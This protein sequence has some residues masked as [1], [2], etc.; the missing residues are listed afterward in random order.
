MDRMSSVD[1]APRQ[2][3]YLGL[4]GLVLGLGFGALVL[5][6]VA[7]PPRLPQELPGWDAVTFTLQGSYLPLGA[8]AYVLTTAAWAVWL[9]IV[10]SLALR[11]VVL[12]TEAMTGGA[13]WVAGLRSVSDRVT[14][15]IV[16]RLVDGALVAIVVVNLVG[17]STPSAA[18]AVL[19]SAA[20][21]SVVA[22]Q[23]GAPPRQAFDQSQPDREQRVVEYTVQAGDTLWGIAERF[24]GTGHEYPR[25]VA[26][27][28]GRQMPDGRRFT[29]AGVIYPGWV[30]LVH[31]TSQGTEDAGGQAYY[32]VEER[33][34]LRGIAARVLDDES[35]WS[36]IFELNRGT[37]R[38]VDGRVLEDPGLIWPGLRLRLPSSVP[39]GDADEPTP[40]A[41]APSQEDEPVSPPDSPIVEAQPTVI[42]A[43]PEGEVVVDEPS[44]ALTPTAL[45]EPE[46]APSTGAVSP[47]VYGAAGLVTIAVTGGAM[48]LARRRVRRSLD[49]LPVRAVSEVGSPP[50]GDFA[51]AEFGRVLAHRL[52]GDE[53][54]P[55]VLVAEQVLRFLGEHGM[56]EASVVMA[57]Q[58]RNATTL[59]L[60]VGLLDQTCLLDL[61]SEFGARL[62]G[63][64]QA[65]ITPDHD[66]AM[67]LSGLKLAGVITPSSYRLAAPPRLLPVGVIPKGQTLY[68]NWRE[69]GHILVAGL[70]GGGTGVVLTS[71]ISALA[72]RCR[73]EE[74][75]LWTV[76]DRRLLPAQLL[77]LPHQCGA[78]VD[79]ADK[80]GVSQV[81]QQVRT[82]LIRRMRE[83]EREDG[84]RPGFRPE[85]PEIVLAIGELGNLEDD[86]TTLELIGVHGAAHGVRLLAATTGPAELTVELL[87]HFQT[88]LVLQTLD[89]EES[90]R[91]LGRPDAAD[92]GTGDLLLR[93]D[94]R[95]LV[96]ARGFRVSSDR[97]DELVR[98]MRE[99]YGCRTPAVV[100]TAATPDRAEGGAHPGAG[101]EDVPHA[102]ER[103][104]TEDRA[105]LPTEPAPEAVVKSSVHEQP[106]RTDEPATP[107]EDASE[108]DT[109]P[110]DL[111]SA[112]DVAVDEDRSNGHRD[113]PAPD[114]ISP[115]DDVGLR[116]A[117]TTEE[118]DESSNGHGGDTVHGNT[119]VVVARGLAAKEEIAPEAGTLVQVRCFGEFLV[120][121]G[122]REITPS[123]E[124]GAS[125]KAWEVLAFLAAQ[126]DG[127]VSREKLLAAVWPDVD[128]E[129]AGNRMRVAMVRLR[130][131]LARQ[132]PC[133][134]SEAVR[135]DRD[136]TC[137]LDTKMISSD[138]HQFVALCRTTPKLPPERA[139]AVLQQA[140]ALYGGELLPGR[141]TRLYEWVDERDESGVSLREAYREE[142]YRATQRLARLFFQEGR[143]ELAVPLYRG[144]LKAE[145]TLE[146]IVRELYRCYQ[147]IGDLSSLIREDRHLRQALR[148]AYH[149][150]DDPE[151]NP[152]DYQPEP[153]TIELFSKIRRELE[154]KVAARGDGHRTGGQ[155]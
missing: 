9:W 69:L 130:A 10:A 103:A 63:T 89:D 98:L 18:A 114:H 20:T 129:R 26:D 59:A 125:F 6:A 57:R 70:P 111:V 100:A 68:A 131:L 30:L 148:E 137:R 154:R 115:T 41:A 121:S 87:A 27:N 122:E 97:L 60:S 8:V 62:G 90:V 66:L 55:V 80:A 5:Y 21:V 4:V 91:L 33:D 73:P 151:D 25:I 11:L 50:G 28:V 35:R 16:R 79:P 109:T 15:P 14:L 99:A 139:K 58:G 147:Q 101:G 37:A 51:E 54:E 117:A 106:G 48:V 44:A 72:A 56:P 132:V 112:A 93:I 126:P 119:V 124:E 22:A 85:E 84:P 138:V 145:P 81:L 120:M 143:A 71:L 88:R 149:D 24:Y 32:T 152:D 61:A 140:R 113:Q 83:S 1:D 141:G 144:L 118:D 133:L 155:R 82:E 3:G 153:E 36:E 96:R 64:G 19:T 123:S 76:A 31:P 67:Q 40:E 104:P 47:L 136:G 7:G 2:A 150:P 78:L 110:S 13:P 34:T 45:V 74:L 29:Q 127:A 107:T 108:A 92:L 77:Q 75:H 94:G 135:A 43:S 38:L 23:E 128:A 17:R 102:G 142:Y 105:A 65:S 53:V 12:G 49:E 116:P 39:D 42:T 134:P 46:P 86:G 52:H 95:V 146:D